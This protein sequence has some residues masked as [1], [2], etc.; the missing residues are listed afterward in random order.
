MIRNPFK[1]KP[2]SP[3]DQALDA[4]DGV[5]TDAASAA[6]EIRDAA[7]KVADA[8]GDVDVPRE[9]RLPLIGAA[10]AAGL[11]LALAIRV[12]A[13]RGSDPE[14]PASSTG[15]VPASPATATAAKTTAAPVTPGPV[16]AGEPTS[17]KPK[18]PRAQTDESEAASA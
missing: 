13:K 9:R 7:A 12:R 6:G 4:L 16:A 10:A 5:R 11:G 18:E 14:V 1:R 2:K 17:E 15:A 8:L 3:L